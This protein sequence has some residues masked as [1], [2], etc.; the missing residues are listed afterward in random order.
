MAYNTKCF[1][2]FIYMGLAYRLSFLRARGVMNAYVIDFVAN[3]RRDLC[4][5]RV[6]HI[7]HES[8]LASH[9]F[10]TANFAAHIYY[11]FRRS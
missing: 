9:H 2:G 10:S 3:K 4:G 11:I 8:Y 6:R 1:M 5:C 7:L